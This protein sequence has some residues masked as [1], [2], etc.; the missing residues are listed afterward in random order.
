MSP[1]KLGEEV[2]GR[3]LGRS[4]GI[5]DDVELVAGSR[6]GDVGRASCGAASALGGGG[7]PAGSGAKAVEARVVA[8]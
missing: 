5:R 4:G 7:A 6:A 2:V 1:E 8:R 3:S